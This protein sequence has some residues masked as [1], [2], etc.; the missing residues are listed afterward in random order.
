MPYY[1]TVFDISK[2][3]LPFPNVWPWIILAML[4]VLFMF[5]QEYYKFNGLREPRRALLRASPA[6]ALC[7]AVMAFEINN[8]YAQYRLLSMLLKA[9]DAGRFSVAEGVVEH[10][11]SAPAGGHGWEHFCVRSA[12]FK[13]DDAFGSVVFHQTSLN[14]GPITRN[15][16][17]VRVEY[18]HAGITKIEVLSND[19]HGWS[20]SD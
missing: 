9:V 13:Y 2:I 10:F 17:H 6:I 16:M 7:L 8:S 19:L 11:K 12:C 18:T 5:G 1:V 4:S 20:N 3:S 15:G 14:R